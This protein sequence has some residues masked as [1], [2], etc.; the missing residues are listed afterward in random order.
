MLKNCQL[1]SENICI[2]QQRKKML[3]PR[4]IQYL[5][6][7]I[8]VLFDKTLITRLIE[9]DSQVRREEEKL[10]SSPGSI[11]SNAHSDCPSRAKPRG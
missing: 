11:L 8:T 5:H 10:I 3:Q 4:E 7:G 9:R 1:Y 6:A 2:G